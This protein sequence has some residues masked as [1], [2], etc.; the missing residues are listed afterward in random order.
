MRVPFN[1]PGRQVAAMRTQIDAAVAS[2]LDSGWFIGGMQHDSFESDFAG[3][4]GVSHCV[5]VGNG[6][7]ALEIALRALGCTAG[8]E[9]VTVANAGMYATTAC[10]LVGATP[11]YVDIDPGTLEM[12]CS[13]LES[14]ISR[15][16][17]AIV[18]TH[19]YG[20]LAD[21]DAIMDVGQTRGIAVIEDCAQAHGAMRHG[22]RAG[23]FGDVAT[24]SFYP[25]K[26]LGALGDGGAIVTSHDELAERLRA[27]R[28]YGWESK[29]HAVVP[30]GRNSRLD[31]VQAAILR[32]RLPR[33]DAW[34]ERRRD[35]VSAY[36]DAALDTQLCIVHEPALDFVAHLCVGRHPQRDAFRDDLAAGGVD[37]AIH[38]ATPDHHQPAVT[39]VGWRAGSLAVTEA[40]VGEIV[41]L[42]CFPELTDA[43]VDYVC[44][45]IGDRA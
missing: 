14:V 12:D 26:N 45:V 19:L 36:T 18:A 39:A 25:T 9:V 37:T 38:F 32:V 40:V 24:F 31:E 41:S 17:K 5:G 43:E 44:R 29:Y 8:D 42:P 27:L 34:N 22:R 23:S 15:S 13:A 11:V 20:K 6:T 3:Y 21:M 28:Q 2:V 33:L 10:L 7:D 35:I 16:T 4:C 30:G 1:D